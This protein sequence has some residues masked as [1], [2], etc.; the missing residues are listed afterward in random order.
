MEVDFNN[1]RRSL[2]QNYNKLVETVANPDRV[3]EES[4]DLIKK[5]LQHLR[6]DIVT[7]ACCYDDQAGIVSLADEKI[8]VAL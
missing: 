1:L 6:N 8:L 3:P 5:N 4:Y 2:I 7:L